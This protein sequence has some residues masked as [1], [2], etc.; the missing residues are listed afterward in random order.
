VSDAPGTAI[1]VSVVSTNDECDSAFGPLTVGTSVQGSVVGATGD[2]VEACGDVTNRGAGVWYTV[3]GTGS[4]MTAFTCSDFTDFDTQIAVYAGGNC[5][6][7]TCMG[8]KDDNC[9]F[10]TWI[11]FPTTEGQI[12]HILV[13]GKGASTGGFVLTL[14]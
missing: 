4:T 11:T 1:N 5:A 7:L 3:L 10:S 6:G 2:N 12:L 13:S 8:G 14:R 9:G